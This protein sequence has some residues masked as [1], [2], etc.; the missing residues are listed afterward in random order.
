MEVEQ[1]QDNIDYGLYSRQLYVI[2]REAQ[3][4]MMTSNVLLCGV[5]GLGV[6]IGITILL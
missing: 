5:K 1:P 4:R 2:G 6:E 3:K